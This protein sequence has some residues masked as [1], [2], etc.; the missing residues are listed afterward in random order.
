MLVEELCLGCFD[1]TWRRL[2]RVREREVNVG[3]GHCDVVFDGSDGLAA[4][5]QIAVLQPLLEGH[6]LAPVALETMHPFF[7]LPLLS[8]F[9]FFFRFFTTTF[10]FYS[11]FCSVEVCFLF[12]E[13]FKQFMTKLHKQLE[14]NFAEVG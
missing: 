6:Q 11:F 7:L 14:R 9:L 1:G 3:G 2:E 12:D 13:P 5:A 10:C 4:L 8:F